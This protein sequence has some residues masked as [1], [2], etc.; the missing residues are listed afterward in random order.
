MVPIRSGRGIVLCG[1]IAT[2]VGHPCPCS[3][4]AVS[5]SPATGNHEGSAPWVVPL[6]RLQWEAQPSAVREFERPR[7]L[8]YLDGP[9]DDSASNVTP[10]RLHGVQQGK[11]GLL[12]NVTGRVPRRR[13]MTWRAAVK[14]TAIKAY[15]YYTLRYRASGLRR[16]HHFLP[17]LSVTGKEPSGNRSSI[18]LLDS[19]KII[20]DDRWH[21]HVGRIEGDFTVESL[22]VHVSTT[23]SR[24]LFEVASITFAATVPQTPDGFAHDSRFSGAAQGAT[25]GVRPIP[26]GA[27]L[28]DTCADAFDRLLSKYNGVV[29]GV[30]GFKGDRIEAQGVPFAVR[31]EGN[32]IARPTEDTTFN[33]ETVEF[34]GERIARVNFHRPGR[35]DTIRVEVK[36]NVSEVFLLLVCEFPVVQQR[37]GLPDVPFAI[38]DVEV[39]SVE[40]RY[41]DGRVD[42]AFPYSLAD[43]GH[44]LSRMTGVY[45]VAADPGRKLEAVVFHN[46]LFGIN[47]SVAA[48][49]VNTAS[50]RLVPKLAQVPAPI[51]VPRL[52]KPPPRAPSVVRDAHRIHCGN[53]F[54]DLVI[55]CENG[56]SLERIVNRWSGETPIRLHGSSG[57]EVVVGDKVLTGRA[58]TTEAV[59]VDSSSATITLR[60]RDPAAP[61][62]LAVRVSVDESPRISFDLSVINRGTDTVKAEIRFPAMNGLEIGTFEGTRMFFP[63][64]CNVD[65]GEKG[66]YLASNDRAFPMQFFDAYNPA[67]G[68][69]LAV[70]THNRDHV[71]IDYCIGKTDSG[72]S[73][74]V[75]YPEA[76]SSFEPG[77]AVRLPR[78]QL[79]PH[80]GD[81][82]QAMAAYQDWLRSWYKPKHAQDKQWFKNT[83]LIRTHTTSEHESRA[84]NRTPPV[85]DRA[86]GKF[87]FDEVLE[88]DRAYRG[89]RPD[90]V[91]LYNWFYDDANQDVGH[92]DYAER[93]YAQV[94][95]L[96]AFRAA[97]GHLQRDAGIPVSL[98]LIGDRC[99]RATAAGKRFGEKYVSRRPDGSVEATDKVWYMCLRAAPWQD[100]FVANVCRV[101]KQT[102]A[103]VIYLDVFGLT[104][105][106]GCYA[107]DHGH[108]TPSLCNRATY[109]T[110]SKVR[111][112]L[113]PGVAVWCEYPLDDVSSQYIDGNITYTFQTLHEHMVKGHD[114]GNRIGREAQR[115]QDVYRFV[116]PHIKQFGFA[117]GMEHDRTPSQLKHL[118]FNGE[119]VYDT[120]WRLYAPRTLAMM[121]NSLAIKKR[122]GDCFTTDRPV[123]RVP[124]LQLGVYANQFPGQDRTAWTLYNARYTTVR[125]PVIA[126]DHTAG[127]TY[128][129]AWNDRPLSPHI[130]DGKATVSVVLDPQGLGC[131]VQTRKNSLPRSSK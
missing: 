1:L 128:H 2:A 98:Y 60:T 117:V 44:V 16:E 81:W 57:L 103:R 90:V 96:E 115:H 129:D 88:A 112:G 126:L 92:G 123:P 102:G 130:A 11:K 64:Y 33:D 95:G 42:S 77:Q 89:L 37:Y 3:A 80:A 73:A 6:A 34:L 36:R 32:D 24:G 46:R 61:L 45:A 5:P 108:E 75:R 49:S 38:S 7:S 74:S 87:R 100:H 23:D 58:M 125:E 47:V 8:V 86:S 79:V 51:R 52:P 114:Q 110:I 118:F 48:V 69:G 14:P 104:R 122:Y 30:R 131:I 124:T 54:Y 9:I 56:F 85:Y 31:T 99:S 35:D 53:R 22:D 84:I 78:A 93:S 97:I 28:N 27:M 113:P 107:H 119:S 63:Q 17:I 19:E 50:R 41:A 101:Q 66:F 70:L 106:H 65:T 105:G 76:F 20:T 43:R 59:E 83:F 109:D 67:A 68:V 13:S 120:T 39:F 62:E 116:F 26:L 4:A 18:S 82:H 71:A 127:A 55:H 72:V 94:G 10:E 21:V 40:L 25:R 12:F 15:R 111:A 121:N 29:D 91:H